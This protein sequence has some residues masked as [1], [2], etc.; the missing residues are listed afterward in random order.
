MVLKDFL[1]R[2]KANSSQVI[3]QNRNRGILPNSFYQATVTLILKSDRDPSKRMT[4][5][6]FL[7]R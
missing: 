2:V 6:F 5:Q 1:G 3:P 7:W 4:D